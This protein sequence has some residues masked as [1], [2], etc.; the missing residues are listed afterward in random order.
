MFKARGTK[1][2]NG[3]AIKVEDIVA[4]EPDTTVDATHGAGTGLLL[5]FVADRK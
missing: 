4:R 1:A 5:V 3:H 2:L